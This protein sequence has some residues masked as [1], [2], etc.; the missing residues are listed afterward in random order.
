M[1]LLAQLPD[2]RTN[3][4]FEKYPPGERGNESPIRFK[5]LKKEAIGM[6]N[7][8]RLKMDGG[9][10]KTYLILE[11]G[12]TET[13][14]LKVIQHKSLIKDL[15]IEE[16]ILK[17]SVDAAIKKNRIEVLVGEASTET[18]AIAEL[19]ELRSA[20]LEIKASIK[21]L[22]DSAFDSMTTLL[23]AFL[24]I[25]WEAIVEKECDSDDFVS[26]DGKK[27]TVARGRNMGSLSPCYFKFVE[28]VAPSDCAE[29]IFRYITTNLHFHCLSGLSKY[30]INQLIGR[31]L[32]LNDY[33]KYCPC[34][35]HMLGSP[36]E[37]VTRAVAISQLDLVTVI[38]NM[39]PNKVDAKLRA[40]LKQGEFITDV[41]DLLSR[42]ETICAKIKV[43]SHLLKDF[44][45]RYNLR[46]KGTA[47]TPKK[48]GHMP[49]LQA[50]IPKKRKIAG[51]GKPGPH[52]GGGQKECAYCLKFNSK[53]DPKEM[54]VYKTHETANCSKYYPDGN[55][56][57]TYGSSK[58]KGY[59]SHKSSKSGGGKRVSAHK[60]KK[61]KKKQEKLTK[62]MF[63][64]HVGK[65]KSKKAALKALN[66]SSS[67]SSSSSFSSSSY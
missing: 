65:K 12:N 7:V 29:E 31:L 8:T 61:L 2:S 37:L 40:S 54:Y 39:L 18:R 34:I 17:L 26:L 59:A 15:R 49:N 24:A 38:M 45:D 58:T 43:D 10:S 32:E 47:G 9:I 5:P 3:G 48:Q 66:S 41:P 35:K 50:P 22:V 57:T 63:A 62:L 36:D 33:L 14:I 13:F 21:S 60:L 42:L 4:Q 56:K 20:K 30:T 46:E 53:T 55:I 1:L 52:S 25:K 6:K 11:V 51:G 16:K 67:S 23:S 64:M 28:L 44:A 27:G 19:E